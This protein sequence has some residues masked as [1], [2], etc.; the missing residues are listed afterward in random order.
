MTDT[1]PPLDDKAADAAGISVVQ[2]QNCMQAPSGAA[3]CA[4]G[5]RTFTDAIDSL[6]GRAPQNQPVRTLMPAYSVS[7][8]LRLDATFGWCLRSSWNLRQLHRVRMAAGNT[9]QGI[10]AWCTA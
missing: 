3:K 8:T 2:S 7:F 10:A 4:H 6:N 5:L 1:S 9:L